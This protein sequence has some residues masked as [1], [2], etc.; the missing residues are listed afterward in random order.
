MTAREHV[1]NGTSASRRW[2]ITLV[3]TLV[4]AFTVLPGAGAAFAFSGSYTMNCQT[5]STIT[6]WTA[7]HTVTVAP[8][9]PEV[10]QTVTITHEF[11]NGGQ[12][13]PVG[14]AAGDLVPTA[15]IALSGAQSGTVD[16]VGPAYGALGTYEVI[17]GAVMTGTF[18]ATSS[19]PITATVEEVVFDHPDVITTCNDS[20][21]PVASP[22]ATSITTTFTVTGPS[23]VITNV[24]GQ[25]VTDFART[26][27]TIEFDVALF[28]PSTTATVQMCDL[29]GADC[30][31][32]SATVSLDGSGAG[33][34]AILLQDAPDTTAGERALTVSDGTNTVLVPIT[35]GTTGFPNTSSLSISPSA[36][37]LGTTVQVTLNG[38]DPLKDVYV[39]TFVD[40]PFGFPVALS[41]EV[42]YPPVMVTMDGQGS[43]T[44][45]VTVNDPATT[46]IGATQG[47]WSLSV[48]VFA[49]SAFAL[50][51]DEC[52][53]PDGGS[54]SL[55]YN[56]DVTVEAG[57]LSMARQTGT[58]QIQL[59]PVTTSAV[60]VVSTGSLDTIAVTDVRG[61]TVG[62]SLVGSVTDFGSASGAT[63]DADNL[64][65]APTCTIVTAV[66]GVEGTLVSAASFVRPAP[67]SA[68]ASAALCSGLDNIAG[69]GGVFE[70]S[71]DIELT[72][73]AFQQADDYSAVLTIT[74]S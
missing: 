34:G 66:S 57:T 33:S 65:W 35:V 19:G 28:E 18:V 61:G 56:L 25:L 17:P 50:S 55:D 46:Y 62:W 27:D 53:A 8:A 24:D 2:A 26:G 74:L 12:T 14:I 38:F 10:G 4:A 49:F 51:G 67:G 7:N 48:D 59:S 37:G 47:A 36:G 45:T 54:C 30:D 31:A 70:A 64:A 15:T 60:D 6:S 21:T 73:P 16:L 40:A 44:A 52:T 9:A 71:A 20:A 39:G 69:T 63:I 32:N 42:L 23:V 58:S 72:V 11:D 22:Q 41:D 13:G 1:H 43:G 3:V 68:T 29:A 5:L